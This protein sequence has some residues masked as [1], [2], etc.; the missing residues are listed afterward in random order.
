MKY[1]HGTNNSKMGGASPHNHYISKAIVRS[2]GDECASMFMTNR[3]RSNY[4]GTDKH[5]HWEGAGE[6]W[7]GNVHR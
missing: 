2:S 5:N 3:T 4:K 1:S 6:G 7:G